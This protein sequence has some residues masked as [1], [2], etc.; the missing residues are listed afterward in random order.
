MC[1]V[2]TQIEI[3]HDLSKM[4]LGISICSPE[5]ENTKQKTRNKTKT[6][7]TT[8]MKSRGAM[9]RPDKSFIFQ[10]VYGIAHT[11]VYTI[12]NY[13]HSVCLELCWRRTA[14]ICLERAADEH[15]SFLHK[16]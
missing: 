15:F 16:T 7:Y 4:L 11:F 9:L 12:A 10:F 5:E 1:V 2:E 13:M 8:R 14:D 3:V 6:S